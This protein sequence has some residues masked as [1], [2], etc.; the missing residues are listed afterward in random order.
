[1]VK[2][3]ELAKKLGQRM[4]YFSIEAKIGGKITGGFVQDLWVVSELLGAV[5][6]D[7]GRRGEKCARWKEGV[8]SGVRVPPQRD[9]ECVWVLWVAA[10]VPRET[11]EDVR[12][13][14]TGRLVRGEQGWGR[15][16]R[17]VNS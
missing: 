15:L 7:G 2:V 6:V 17:S 1:M 4:E 14:A 11:A 12:L 9:A 5:W 16:R 13:S 10:C 3:L 8:A